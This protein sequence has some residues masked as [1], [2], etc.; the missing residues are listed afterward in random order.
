MSS[1]NADLLPAVSLEEILR[2]LC[3]LGGDWSSARVPNFSSAPM[4]N[5][6]LV[7][8]CPGA[9]RPELAPDGLVQIPGAW[10]PEQLPH[11][12][13]GPG[14]VVIIRNNDRSHFHGLELPFLMG[15]IFDDGHLSADTALVTW[16]LPGMSTH[17]CLGP[18]RK[19]QVV[20][21]FSGWKTIESETIAKSASW[22]LPSPL[23][24]LGDVLIANVELE[25]IDGERC[26]PFQI[27]SELKSTHQVDATSLTFSETQRGNLYRVWEMMRLGRS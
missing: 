8:I 20:D 14:S 27:F 17:A 22:K 21:I 1:K 13:V 10:Q 23:V 11:G 26:I 19:K 2:D 18:G 16:M 3:M 25:L 15:G 7:A 12:L 4:P 5:D 6:V 24:P 9:D